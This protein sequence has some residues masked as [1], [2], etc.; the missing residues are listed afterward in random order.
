MKVDDGV[1]I[2]FVLIVVAVI[3]VLPLLWVLYNWNSLETP[4]I[5]V[6]KNFA[7]QTVIKL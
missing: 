7:D 3:V 1:W 5:D 6:V 4:P 2:I